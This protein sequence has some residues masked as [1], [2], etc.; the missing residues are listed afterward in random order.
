MTCE[1][2]NHRLGREVDVHLRD[3]NYM[4]LKQY[5]DT[6][7]VT[8]KPPGKNRGKADRERQLK[9]K[10][11]ILGYGGGTSIERD[12]DFFNQIRITNLP[13][14]SAGDFTYNKLFSRALHKCAVNVMLAMTD[15]E[16]MRR[17]HA[18]VIEFIIG[19]RSSESN[20]DYAL[21]YG[22]MFTSIHFEP[23]LL[24]GLPNRPVAE[25]LF[26]IFPCLVAA[27]GLRPNAVTPEILKWVG[28]HPPSVPGFARSGFDYLEHFRRGLFDS[29]KPQ[30]GSLLR[31]T[32]VKSEP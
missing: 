15:Y 22:D 30:Y 4:M 23:F 6:I 17:N 21:C 7:E 14:G 24:C 29:S 10:Q 16:H 2:C 31:F 26:L 27:V 12:L 11:R 25:V 5:Q 3:Q 28:D 13:D 32:L 20:W 18:D 19:M 8:G 9:R 1:E